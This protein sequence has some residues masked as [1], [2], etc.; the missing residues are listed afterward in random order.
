MLLWSWVWFLLL[1]R[2]AKVQ[3]DQARERRVRTERQR[4]QRVGQEPIL[5][6]RRDLRAEEER[7]L[8]LLRERR[9]KEAR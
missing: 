5:V 8:S 7:L 4:R 2:M 1:R 9:S 6:T 3:D